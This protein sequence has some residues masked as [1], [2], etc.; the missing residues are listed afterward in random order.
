MF[1]QIDLSFRVRSA[2]ERGQNNSNRS[3]SPMIIRRDYDVLSPSACHSRVPFVGFVSLPNCP[4][5][6]EH[7]RTR[8]LARAI[9]LSTGRLLYSRA[10]KSRPFVPRGV[11]TK[12]SPKSLIIVLGTVSIV[13]TSDEIRYVNKTFYGRKCRRPFSIYFS[14][15]PP[16]LCST[17]N[18]ERST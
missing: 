18:G 12:R 13:E 1:R 2:F 10:H 17:G 8:R 4:V 14:P 15:P 16:P 7:Q 3:R 9:P 11:V 6:D 5:M